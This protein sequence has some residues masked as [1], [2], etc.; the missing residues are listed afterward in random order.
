MRTVAELRELVEGLA[1]HPELWA[2]D[3]RHAAGE[4]VCVNLARTEEL[5]VWLICWLEGHDT[6]FHDHDDAAAAITVA[7]GAVRDDR[8]SLGGPALTT[9]HESGATFTVDAGGIHRVRHHGEEPAV[10]LHAYS[11]PLGRMGSYVVAPDGRLLRLPQDGGAELQPAEG[12]AT[13]S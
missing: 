13:R 3:V 10:T 4:R 1:A 9:T 2:D 8:L 7:A 6:G 11:P 12:A 5:E